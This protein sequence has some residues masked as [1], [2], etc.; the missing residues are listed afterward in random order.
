MVI[1]VGWGAQRAAEDCRSRELS[2][3]PAVI[4][5][6]RVSGGLRVRVIKIRLRLAR[7]SNGWVLDRDMVGALNIGLRA[8]SSDGRG[9]ALGSTE[10]HAV[11]A[12]LVSPHRGL[13]QT[14][15]L[16]INIYRNTVV[17]ETLL[18]LGP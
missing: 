4:R 10:P 17:W 2:Y 3:T 14:T 11:W 18:P 8:L 15:E 9:V 16:K 12:K 13:A 7:L 5:V 6:A 1:W